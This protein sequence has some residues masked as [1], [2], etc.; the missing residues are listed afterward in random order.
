MNQSERRK[1][2]GFVGQIQTVIQVIGTAILIWVGSSLIDV[3]DRLI[4]LEILY[5]TGVATSSAE[6]LRIK[7]RL[8]TLERKA[9]K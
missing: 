1:N 3:R 8:D 7:E 5:Q 4:R 9:T 2:S 6:I